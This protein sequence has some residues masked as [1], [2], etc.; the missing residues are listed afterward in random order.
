[1]QDEDEDDEDDEADEEARRGT[2]GMCTVKRM[3]FGNDVWAPLR[4]LMW[5]SCPLGLQQMLT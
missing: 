4:D 5:D 2:V 1:M 3:A